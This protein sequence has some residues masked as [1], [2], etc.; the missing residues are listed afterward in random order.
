MIDIIYEDY[1]DWEPLTMRFYFSHP[2]T[3]E[4]CKELG[5]F[6]LDWIAEQEEY[7]PEK[8]R[9]CEAGAK[10]DPSGMVEVFCELMPS[11]EVENLAA[12][13]GDALPDVS[14][15]RVGLPISGPA[16][17]ASTNWINIPGESVVIDGQRY[18][19]APFTIS[20]S[21][22]TV[23]QFCEFLDETDY[24]PLPDELGGDF[25]GMIDNFKTNF[26]PSPVIPL[27]GLTYD[28]AIAYCEWS[29]HR[30]PTDPELRLYYQNIVYGR[31]A[32]CDWEGNN[33]TSTPAGPD[34]FYLR[35]GPFHELPPDEED[36]NRKPWHRHGY[37]L[38]E[39]PSFRIMKLDL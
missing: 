7:S 3:L 19:V 38:L 5:A 39:A 2:P 36:P 34:H 12:A 6:V 29:G 10:I 1:I 32:I 8:W 26:G 35:Q 31:V 27:M 9:Y 14:E 23:G 16:T 28:D 11:D 24:L 20:H 25:G 22:V 17:L 15:L 30:L 37:H 33:W 21:A 13:V 4:R 18:D